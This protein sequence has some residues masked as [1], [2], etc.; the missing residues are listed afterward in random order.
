M[1]M[2]YIKIAFI[3]IKWDELNISFSI[4]ILFQF[5]L[6]LWILSDLSNFWKHKHKAVKKSVN[7]T[8]S[9]AETDSANIVKKWIE[10]YLCSHTWWYLIIYKPMLWMSLMVIF[11]SFHFLAI[12]NKLTALMRRSRCNFLLITTHK[13]IIS[14][15]FFLDCKAERMIY[16]D[17]ITYL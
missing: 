15:G 4:V 1:S 6:S 7:F 5:L 16:I 12:Y 2:K 11:F 13:G 10:I 14:R 17:K 9:S 3:I 8:L